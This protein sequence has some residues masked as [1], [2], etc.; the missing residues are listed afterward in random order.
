MSIV[1]QYLDAEDVGYEVVH[2][3]RSFTGVDEAK[4]VGIEA[5]EVL[6]TLVFDTD[7]GHVLAVIPGSGR[8]D[9]RR[10][11]DAVGDPHAKLATEKEIERDFHGFELGSLPPLGGL[12]DAET[13]V[14]PRVRDHD[15]VVIAAGSQVESV[16][17]RT[18]E[19]FAKE[20]VHFVG[21]TEG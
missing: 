15:V 14:D 21:I 11:R 6:K 7:R 2:H 9:M 19:V 1:T 16:R 10:L 13:Y 8:L 20:R 5:D 12:L 17:A 18:R 4:A 3:D